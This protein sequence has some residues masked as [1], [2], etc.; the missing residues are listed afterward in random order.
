MDR[1]LGRYLTPSV[2]LTSSPEAAERVRRGLTQLRDRGGAG[3]LLAR[4]TT[5]RDLVRPDQAESLAEA[6]R[7]REVLTPRLLAQLPPE[8]RAR[9]ER[10]TSEEGLSA[11]GFE[12][13]PSLFTL[14]M[15]ETSGQVDRTVLVYP[16]L[17][18]ATWDASRITRY[19]EDI[20]RVVAEEAGPDGVFVS[21]LALSSDIASV[22]RR[23]GPRATALSLFTVLVITLFS[24]RSL[25]LSLWA[26]ASLLAG[27]LLMAGLAAAL[28][29]KLNFSNFVA[30]PITFGIAAEYSINV[31]RRLLEDGGADPTSALRATGGAVA[32]CSITTI[33]GFGSLLVAEQQALFSFGVLAVSGEV[34][35]LLTALVLLP[36]L[37]LRRS[38]RAEVPVPLGEAA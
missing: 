30:L 2:V 36:A 3:A 37:V 6:R 5:A 7:L 34:T 33:I 22:M 19:T 12:E 9:V 17:T 1:A 15:K 21:P 8:A 10:A 24:F 11:F 26:I 4:V 32:L 23:D 31:L 35:C 38:P 14:G 16:R 18:T 25:R 13:I 29:M 27:V 20:R 28:R